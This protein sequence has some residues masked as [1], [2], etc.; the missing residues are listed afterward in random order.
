[1]KHVHTFES[2]L[3]EGN[4]KIVNYSDSKNKIIVGLKSNLLPD[5]LDRYESQEDGDNIH[6][7]D[8]SGKHF[9]TLFDK[10]TRYQM[11][12]HDGSLDDKGWRK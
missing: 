3:N 5:M 2:F 9:G 8:D 1:M 10:G 12:L 7:F 11:L 6:F 4:K